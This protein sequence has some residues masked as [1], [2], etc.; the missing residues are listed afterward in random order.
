MSLLIAP[1][2]P[3]LPSFSP[4]TASPTSLTGIR[5]NPLS[6]CSR[7]NLPA[8]CPIRSQTQIMSRISAS[9]LVASTRRSTFRSETWV[10]YRS[11]TRQSSLP[12]ILIY[13]NI[14]EHQ[15]AVS[16]QQQAQFPLCFLLQKTCADMNRETVVWSLFESES[17]DKRDRDQN[18][19]PKIERQTKPPQNLWQESWN[20]RQRRETD[21]AQIIRS[22]D[23]RGKRNIIKKKK[24][25]IALN[26]MK[27]NDYSYNKRINDLIRL[28]EIK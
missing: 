25:V 10:S 27:S 14:P 12:K 15:A 22:W 9:R 19:A 4:P 18:V 3:F 24:S 21:S 17:K 20:D 16:I 11:T 6:L 1:S 13:L 7:M 5:S 26:E 28:N 2:T 8:I 23:R